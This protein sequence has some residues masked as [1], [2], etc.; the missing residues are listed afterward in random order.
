MRPQALAICSVCTC[1][2]NF[3]LAAALRQ[4]CGL[5]DRVERTAERARETPGRLGLEFYYPNTR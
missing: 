2:S 5:R 1:R 3:R 4:N